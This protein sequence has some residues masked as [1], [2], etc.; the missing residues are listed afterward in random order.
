VGWGYFFGSGNFFS[1]DSLSSL[2]LAV[3]S[4]RVMSA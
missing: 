4:S 1:H 2:I 3:F